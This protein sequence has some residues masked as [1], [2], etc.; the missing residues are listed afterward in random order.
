MAN[1]P[2]GVFS[3]EVIDLER[4]LAGVGKLGEA[5]VMATA[6]AIQ[7]EADYELSLTQAQVPVDTGELKRSG[8]VEGPDVEM[9]IATLNIAYGGPAGSGPTQTLDVD[10]AFWVHENLE[11]HH[12]VGKAKFVED[13]VRS[14]A[15]SGRAWRRM[16]EDIA[17]Q[18]A[19]ITIKSGAFATKGGSW[20][21][22]PKGFRGS[23]RI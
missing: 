23:W 2:G 4:A 3:V 8:R 5:V 15:T 13:P 1:I 16:A 21:R 18:L 17:S 12:K 14:E 20:I 6:N 22:G 10:Y 11:A 9:G 19:G 7:R